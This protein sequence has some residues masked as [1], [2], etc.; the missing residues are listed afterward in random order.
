MSKTMVVRYQTR[1]DAADENQR[2]VEQVFAQLA[3]ED[4]GGIR[5]ATFRLADG[6]TFIHVAVTE[7]ESSPL[8]GLSAFKE[9]S[10]TIGERCVEGPTGSGAT[11]VGSYRFFAE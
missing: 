2:L 5:Y 4:P 6:V 9:F 7:G 8:Q 10:S 3:T 11:A 1:P